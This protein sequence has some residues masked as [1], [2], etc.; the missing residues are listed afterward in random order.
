MLLGQLGG[1]LRSSHSFKE[2]VI[3]H[4]SSDVAPIMVGTQATRRSYVFEWAFAPAQGVGER[5]ESGE[6]GA[7][8]FRWSDQ[9]RG[10]R[11]KYASNRVKTP[12]PVSLRVPEP[13]RSAQ[14]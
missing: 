9:K 12:V 11:I 2:C 4:Q 10:C 5:S 6:A 8:A 13:C 1:W 14:G 7:E 3:A